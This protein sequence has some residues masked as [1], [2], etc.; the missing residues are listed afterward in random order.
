MVLITKH[1]TLDTTFCHQRTITFVADISGGPQ[2]DKLLFDNTAVDT[3]ILSMWLSCVDGKK[4]FLNVNTDTKTGKL[5]GFCL[6]SNRQLPQAKCVMP[7]S[8]HLFHER[9]PL[10]FCKGIQIYTQVFVKTKQRQ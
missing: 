1:N 9:M 6:K 4:L 3:E 2:K 7:L 5:I 10:K 8:A